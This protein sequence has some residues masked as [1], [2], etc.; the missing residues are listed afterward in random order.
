MTWLNYLAGAVIGMV[1]V[2]FAFLYDERHPSEEL[3]RQLRP[4]VCAEPQR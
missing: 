1:L 4:I 2:S 3:K